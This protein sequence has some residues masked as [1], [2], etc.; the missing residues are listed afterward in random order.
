MAVLK[1]EQNTAVAGTF[2]RAYE[3]S[4]NQV[5]G[6]VVSNDEFVNLIEK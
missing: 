5:D 2:S 3:W 6:L 1:L 4:V